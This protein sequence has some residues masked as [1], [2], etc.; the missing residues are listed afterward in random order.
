[1]TINQKENTNPAVRHLLKTFSYCVKNKT[2]DDY[3]DGQ[4]TAWIYNI[5][6][7]IERNLNKQDARS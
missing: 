3:I 4:E 7:K 6:Q 2:L 1:M 5:F